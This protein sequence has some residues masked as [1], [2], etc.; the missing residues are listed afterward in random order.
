MGQTF[1]L[2][3]LWPREQV[4]QP[5]LFVVSIAPSLH[6][7][8][9][10]K[11]SVLATAASSDRSGSC[12]QSSS[13][14]PGQVHFSFSRL[15]K[16]LILI[17]VSSRDYRSCSFR[18]WP[19]IACPDE[20]AGYRERTALEAV[21][22]PAQH[23]RVAGFDPAERTGFRLSAVVAP[24]AGASVFLSAICTAEPAVHSAGSDQPRVKFPMLQLS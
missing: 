22:G 11:L 10:R 18:S 23:R 14:H 16:F 19:D 7:N 3:N 4:F 1:R 12:T 8:P 24:A 15:M 5:P 9:C 17:P 2:L 13:P 21:L 20:S 6:G